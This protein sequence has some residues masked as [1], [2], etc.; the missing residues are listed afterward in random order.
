MKRMSWRAW[1]RHSAT[2]VVAGCLGAGLALLASRSPPEVSSPEPAAEQARE[3]A[4]AEEI[5][6][7]L[8]DTVPVPEAAAMR[9]FVPMADESESWISPDEVSIA[10]HAAIRRL[11]EAGDAIAATKLYLLLSECH[12]LQQPDPFVESDASIE[13]YRGTGVDV[14]RML[15]EREAKLEAC[16][17]LNLPPDE[18]KGRG[19]WLAVAAEAGFIHAQLI[20]ASHPEAVI[21]G[22]REMLQDPAAVQRY[23]VD[24]MRFLTEAAAAGSPSALSM[25][26]DTYNHGIIT[27]RDRAMAHGLLLAATQLHPDARRFGWGERYRDGLSPEELSRARRIAEAY[28]RS[29]RGS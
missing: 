19:R 22:P 26:A 28:V 2:W 16:T 9:R 29:V 3:A 4:A 10:D 17:R 12:Q 1:I 25:L 8:Q 27:T 7:R 24:S 21:G 5:S 6:S 11:A 18:L 20:F 13:A 14:Q 23:R 15:R